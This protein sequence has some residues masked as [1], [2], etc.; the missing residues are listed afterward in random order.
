MKKAIYATIVVAIA[1]VLAFNVSLSMRSNTLSDISLANVEALA[2]EAGDDW[3]QGY[4][5][6]YLIIDTH[7]IPCCVPS[8][9]TSACNYGVV[10]CI[11]I[12]FNN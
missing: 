8:V 5:S 6:G 1:G 12:I 7:M 3:V 11:H 9:P 2:Q 4:T 10:S